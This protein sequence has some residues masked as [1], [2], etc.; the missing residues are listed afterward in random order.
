MSIYDIDEYKYDIHGAEQL[1]ASVLLDS[2]K[3]AEPAEARQKIEKVISL[4]EDG[5]YEING[6]ELAALIDQAVDDAYGKLAANAEEENSA[7][8]ALV[9]MVMKEA[10]GKTIVEHMSYAFATFLKDC[11]TA[12]QK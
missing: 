6:K 12:L 10:D 5:N 1:A 4:K 7:F 8:A 9:R 3:H 2:L 11:F